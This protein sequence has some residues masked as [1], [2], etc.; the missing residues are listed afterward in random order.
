M[1]FDG[2]G[3]IGV[4]GPGIVVGVGSCGVYYGVIVLREDDRL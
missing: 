4:S 2:G 1:C 3:A